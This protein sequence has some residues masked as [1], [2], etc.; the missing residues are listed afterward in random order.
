MS[1]QIT[2]VELTPRS[3]TLPLRHATSTQVCTTTPPKPLIIVAVQSESKLQTEIIVA[4]VQLCAV[5]FLDLVEIK[6]WS[7]PSIRRRLKGWG[8]QMNITQYRDTIIN[9]NL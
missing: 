9:I 8:Q 6:G 1:L 3:P 5:S 7:H 2:I 4:V